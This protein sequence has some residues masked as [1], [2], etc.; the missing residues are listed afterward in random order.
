MNVQTERIENH[1]ARLTV[2]I[3]IDQLDKAKKQAA[4]R[5]SRQVRI[6]GFRKGKAPYRVLVNYIGEAPILE[7]AVELIGNDVYRE[8]LAASE[9]QP[10]SSAA[11]EDFKLSPPTFVFT[12]PLQPE[13][14]LNDYLSVREPFEV[15]EVKDEDVDEALKRLQEEHALVEESPSPAVMGNRVLGDIHGFF[16]DEDDDFDDEDDDVEDEDDVVEVEASDDAEASAGSDADDEADDNDVDDD[17]VDDDDDEEDL[18]DAP[19]HQH[20]AK[21][22]LDT[23]REPVPGFAEALV[24]VE[25]GDTRT[26]EIDYPDDEEKFGGLSGRS[27]KFIVQ[28]DGVEVVTLPELNDDFAARVSEE[29]GVLEEGDEP[30]T[31]VQLR[32]RIRENI[33]KELENQKKSEYVEVVMDQMVELADF[34]YP[35]EMIVNQ[36]DGLIEQTASRIG[37][38]AEDYMSIL[39]QSKETIYQ[40]ETYRTAATRSIERSLIMR[41]ILDKEA[42]TVPDE[43]IQEEMDR[44]LSQFGEQASEYRRLF[45]TPEMRSN[46]ANNLMEELVVER[47][48]AIGRGETTPPAAETPEPAADEPTDAAPTDPASSDADDDSE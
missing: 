45:D 14:E 20:D 40:D 47:I 44:L 15:P 16:L 48:V 38:K 3:D 43:R 10:Y 1:S 19:I 25:P 24:G 7:E 30:L 6:P 22:Y 23:E 31:M 37:L 27:V 9:L 26:F 18:H 12:V 46:I 21:I 13:V 36:I 29:D 8:A 39:G 33:G 42:I 4:K 41:G 35:E 28:V 17:D 34:A 32:A 5:L 2:E 11:L